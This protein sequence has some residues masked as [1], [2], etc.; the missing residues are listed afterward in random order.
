MITVVVVAVCAFVVVAGL[1]RG[2]GGYE[3]GSGE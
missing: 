1:V 3:P 2:I